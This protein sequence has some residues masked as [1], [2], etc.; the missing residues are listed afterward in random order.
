MI[1]ALV[2]GVPSLLAR[3]LVHETGMFGVWDRFRDSKNYS[4][5]TIW[6]RIATL[7]IFMIVAVIFVLDKAKKPWAVICGIDGQLN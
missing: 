4:F 3:D 1:I 7:G 5:L 6:Q 2:A